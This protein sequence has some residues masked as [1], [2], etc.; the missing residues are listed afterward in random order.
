MF[1][2]VSLLSQVPLARVQCSTERL[3]LNYVIDNILHGISM[4]MFGD[5]Q[6]F[7]VASHKSTESK[8]FFV[9]IVQD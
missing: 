9:N 5:Y 3:V 1:H 4:I 6:K 8:I 7:R 2:S